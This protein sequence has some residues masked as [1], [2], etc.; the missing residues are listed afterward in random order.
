[1]PIIP[2][3]FRRLSWQTA[4]TALVSGGIIHITATLIMPRF[5]T[6]SAYHRLAAQLPANRMRVLPAA[7]VDNQ[8]LPFIGPDV[9]LAVCRYDVSDGPVTVTAQL[10][11]RGWTLGLYTP[12]GDNFYVIPAQDFRRAEVNFRLAPQTDR[13]LGFINLGRT[14]DT[15]ASEV[16]VPQARGLIVLRAPIRGRAYQAEAEAIL[17]RAQCSTQRG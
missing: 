7:T 17:G 1:M 5:A 4:V 14:A 10:P 2:S 11:D 15:S 13:F 12:T 9:R 8:P 3:W 16:T 6:A